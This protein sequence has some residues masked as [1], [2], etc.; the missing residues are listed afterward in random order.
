MSMKYGQ[1]E[2]HLT[3]GNVP[4]PG[5]DFISNVKLTLLGPWAGVFEVGLSRASCARWVLT[6]VSFHLEFEDAARW[7]VRLPSVLTSYVVAGLTGA[8][9]SLYGNGI[10]MKESSKCFTQCEISLMGLFCLTLSNA[11]SVSALA[12]VYDIYR[13][14]CECA[15]CFGSVT[16]PL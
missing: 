6:Q 4:I 7:L 1:A 11:V 3:A 15:P 12:P 9:P 14:E 2:Q 10:L 5:A 8:V 13:R 16:R